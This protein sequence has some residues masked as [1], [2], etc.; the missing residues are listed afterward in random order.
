M[1]LRKV[2]TTLLA[3][4]LSLLVIFGVF[5]GEWRDSTELI[6]VTVTLGLWLLPTL[7]LYGVPVTFLSDYVSKE[8]TG[9][10]RPLIALI[11]HLCFG[12]LFGLI[13]PIDL[14]LS[15]SGTE[16]NAAITSASITSFFFWVIDELLRV[17]SSNK[18]YSS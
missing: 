15:F 17:N 5:F 3:T 7:L 6:V 12:L 18:K 8:F 14:E 4:P 13:A 10:V 2:V 11:L 16:V 1:I 9:N